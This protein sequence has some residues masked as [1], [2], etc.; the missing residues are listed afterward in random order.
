[1]PSELRCLFFQPDEVLQAIKEYQLRR[2]TP[3]PEASVLQ[4]SPERDAVGGLVRFRMQLALA[5]SS[6]LDSERGGPEC[7]EVIIEEPALSAALIY[8]C[9]NF[10]IPLPAGTEK[11]LQLIDGQIGLVVRIVPGHT[12]MPQLSQIRL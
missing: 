2:G 4:A 6:S 12:A 1:M 3:L 9:R 7:R 8:Y 10:R 5:R 11:S